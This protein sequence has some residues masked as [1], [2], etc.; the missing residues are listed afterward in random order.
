M[1]AYKDYL[2]ALVDENKV[3]CEKIGSGNWYWSFP[4]ADKIAKQKLLDDAQSV[5]DK[6]AAAVQELRDKLAEKA[7]K[8]EEEEDM[9][10][11][12]AE[13]REDVM[14][15]KVELEKELRALGNQLATYS[16]NDPTE[17]ERKKEEIKSLSKD[18]EEYSDNIYSMEGWVKKE[19]GDEAVVELHK[20]IYGD[21][22]DEDAGGL[23]ELAFDT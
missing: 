9:L 10:D 20:A 22:Y 4:S 3:R 18:V 16:E 5:H 6:A 14:A 13:T 19:Y 15:V 7:L 17:L 1:S 21:E 2:Q 8:L 11:N 23:R 12:G